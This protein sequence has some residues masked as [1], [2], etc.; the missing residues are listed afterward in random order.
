MNPRKISASCPV[1]TSSTRIALIN[2]SRSVE[3]IA[4]PA[5]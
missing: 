1:N 3:I 2:G 4:L 5:E